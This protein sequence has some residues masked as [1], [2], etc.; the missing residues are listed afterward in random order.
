MCFYEFVLVLILFSV[1]IACLQI[2]HSS[3]E[4]KTSKLLGS[5]ELDQ[6]FT[7]ASESITTTETKDIVTVAMESAST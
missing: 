5:K 6:P 2:S 1:F 3:R 7:S 4:T